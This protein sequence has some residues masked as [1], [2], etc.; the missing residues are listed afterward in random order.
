MADP[1]LNPTP[2][3]S[4]SIS[5]FGRPKVSNE[6]AAF[7]SV[8]PEVIPPSTTELKKTSVTEVS[9]A[10]AL[11]LADSDTLRTLAAAQVNGNR[12][13][14]DAV[15][16][17]LRTL[18]YGE[19]ALKYGKEV[20]DNSWKILDAE[21]QFR[22]TLAENRSDV[23]VTKDTG[24]GIAQ[25]AFNLAGSLAAL[26][27]GAINDRA[28]AATAGF[29]EQGSEW[30][31]DQKS[32]RFQNYAEANELMSALDGQD[33]LAEYNEAMAE[34]GASELLENIKFFGRSAGDAVGRVATDPALMGDFVAQNIGSL[35]PSVGL[36]KGAQAITAGTKLA[37]GAVPAAV[38]L[39]ESGAAYVGA[40]NRVM[41]MSPEELAAGSE[42][43]RRLIAEG[44]SHEEAAIE[45]STDAGMLAAL[46]QAPLAAAAGKFVERFEVSPT[47]VGSVKEGLAD[48][49][50]QI[51][52]EGF[53][54]GSGQF[55]QN[56]AIQSVADENQEI[57]EGVAEGA[58]L[59]A[60][61]GG[62]VAGL[63]QAPGIAGQGARAAVGAAAGAV[64]T[65]LSNID[66]QR[67]AASP[68]GTNATA[69]AVD[70]AEATMNSVVEQLDTDTSIDP[71]AE[72][73]VDLRSR[74]VKAL[75]VQQSDLDSM[76]E[77]VRNIV[78]PGG[79][80]LGEGESVPRALVTKAVMDTLQ[81][82][83]D[84]ETR[85]NAIL[86]L[87]E[88]ASIYESLKDLD[89]STLT[90]SL[91]EQINE[92]RSQLDTIQSNPT[93][94]RAVELAPTLTQKDLG[95]LP[96][97]TDANVGT[98]EVQQAVAR[99]SQLA[100]V[101]PTG[102]D[103]TYARVILNQVTSG[104]LGMEA[105][106]V[107]RLEAAAA[108]SELYA[109]NG[110]QKAT[111]S[112]G[113]KPEEDGL[114]IDRVR[115]MI[116]TDGR[117]NDLGQYGLKTHLG[118]ILSAARAG[119]KAQTQLLMEN[120]WNFNQSM[121][122]KL[123]AAN[124][125]ME[126]QPGQNNKVKYQAWNG[127]GWSEGEVYV[128]PKSE[129]SLATGKAIEAD[130]KTVADI[131]QILAQGL[132]MPANVPAVETAAMRY[133]D[134]DL[135]P[136]PEEQAPPRQR[137]LRKDAVLKTK[138]SLIDYDDVA[139]EPAPEPTPEPPPVRPTRPTKN[140]DQAPTPRPEPVQEIESEEYTDPNGN[141]FV[142][143]DMD[144]D[145]ISRLQTLM[146]DIL[147][148]S[149]ENGS[150]LMELVQGW[151]LFDVDGFGG[152]AEYDRRKILLQKGIVDQLLGGGPALKAKQ[153]LLHELGHLIDAELHLDMTGEEGQISHTNIWSLPASSVGR[154][155]KEILADPKHMFHAYLKRYAATKEG[156]D[157]NE[158]VFA[159]LMG[160]FLRN[161]QRFQEVAPNVYY[162]FEKRL[163][164][165][166]GVTVKPAETEPETQTGSIGNAANPEGQGASLV[167]GQVLEAAAEEAQ[168]AP[169]EEAREDRG[170]PAGDDST[171]DQTDP[172]EEGTSIEEDA[173]TEPTTDVGASGSGSVRGN[174]FT[175]LVKSAKGVV[176]F[177]RAY[178]I[179]ATKSLLVTS[180]S[181]IESVL[182]SVRNPGETLVDYDLDENQKEALT[183]LVQKEVRA[184]VDGM[185]AKLLTIPR[186]A[187]GTPTLKTVEGEALSPLDALAYGE[188]DFT[189]FMESRVLNLVDETTGEFDP[190]LI[191]LAAMAAMHW[192]MHA[193]PAKIPDA[194]E[195]A[196]MFGV[197]ESEVSSR[198]MEA[199]RNAM[200]GSL[201]V[202][203]LARE[204]MAFWGAK[205]NED[206]PMSDSLGIAQGLAS[207]LLSVMKGKITE[208]D[209]IDITREGKTVQ[210]VAIKTSHPNTDER[211]KQLSY[212][213]SYLKEAFIR[214]DEKP[215]YFDQPPAQVR[216]KQKRNLI[217]KLGS[218]MQKA[219]RRH[220]EQKFY[221]NT[222]F[223]N[224]LQGIGQD[225]W[226]DL[227]GFQKVI[228]DLMNREHRLSV[229]GR[230]T[231]LQKSWEG[232]MGHN[233]RLEA[234]AAKAG[235]NADD[236]VT[237]FDVYA[238]SNERIHQDGFNPQ[239]NKTMREAWA[240]TESI[241]DLTNP[242]DRHLFWLTVAQSSGLIKTE[243]VFEQEGEADPVYLHAKTAA[244]AEKKIEDTYGQAIELL[245][246][247]VR[248][249]EFD[250]K[251][252]AAAVKKA[253][254]G[255]E[256]LIHSL[257]AVAQYRV[258]MTS[259][260]EGAKTNFR[261]FLSLEADGKTD[262][263]M[264]ALVNHS[265]GLFTVD[266]I[267]NFRRGGFFLAQRGRTLNDQKRDGDID[268]YQVASNGTKV[269]LKAKI[270]TMKEKGGAK[271]AE[272][273]LRF[274]S[275]F[276][277]EFSYNEKTE[278]I[279]INRGLLKN[280]L[281]VSV[282]GSGAQGIA[283]KISGA[284]LEAFYER[285]TEL[286]MMRAETGNQNLQ[287]ADLPG[288]GGYTGA[289]DDLHT[290]S[291]SQVRYT[292]K[293]GGKYYIS[294]ETRD[295]K[296]APLKIL[297]PK[298]LVLDAK[299][300]EMLAHNL[301]MILVA[302]MREGIGQVMANPQEV[303]QVLQ[304]A[305]QIQS[306]TMIAHFRQAVK[307]TL[308]A[309]RASGELERGEFLSQDD[310]NEIYRK[311][312]RFGAVIEPAD[313]NENHLNLSGSESTKSSYEFTRSL[314]GRYGGSTR[315]PE[316]SDAGVAAAAM[317]TI[318]RGDAM[319]MVNYFASQDPDLRTLAVF[320]GL[321]MPADGIETISKQIN[322]AVAE[323]W[324]DDNGPRDLADSFADFTRQGERGPFADIKDPEALLE[325]ARTMGLEDVKADGLVAAM[326][327]VAAQVSEDLNQIATEIQAR[328]NVMKS[329][330]YSMDHMA[331][332]RAPHT[333]EGEVFDADPSDP[334][335]DD[336]LVGW[337]NL[338]YEEELSKLDADRQ[339]KKDRPSVEKPS[340]AF[341]KKVKE[342]G[343]EM[344]YRP[345]TRM[346]S[347]A[348]AKMMQSEGIAKD[349][350]DVLAVIQKALPDFTFLFG[351]SEEL[352]AYRDETY[353]EMIG[354]S[355][356][357]L[358]QADINNKVVYIAN[359]TSETVL[360]EAIHTATL[361]I[362]YQAYLDPSQL[363]EVQR[364]AIENLERLMNQFM[365]M[366]FS[367]A[368]RQ[369][370][371]QADG[372]VENVAHV[373]Q[374]QI[375]VAQSQGDALGKAIALNE[376]M[377]WA[378]SNQNLIDVM[379]KTKVRTPLRDLVFKA[380]GW[381]RKL[382]GLAPTQK[383]D[384]FS[385]ILLNTGAALM[386]DT[387][388]TQVGR[389]VELPVGS[390]ANQMIGQP[391][392]TRL[393]TVMER[394]E[395]KIAA[396]LR[397]RDPLVNPGEEVKIFDNANYAVNMFKFHGFDMDPQQTSAF[398]SIQV[399][400][401]STMQMDNR[402]LI[403][404]Q[405]I[406]NH[407]TKQLKPSDFEGY[408]DGNLRSQSRF[409]M[410]LG[411]YGYETD[412]QGRSNLMA[413]FLALSQVDP[414]FRKV[415]DGIDLPKDR[416]V[417]RESMDELLTSVTNSALDTLA[418]AT[419]GAGIGSRTTREALDRL[420]L[421]LSE[422]ETDD[423]LW[424]EKKAQDLFDT[425][426]EKG[427]KFLS[428]TGERIGQWADDQT[429]KS[430]GQQRNAVKD[431]I[432][433]GATFVAS[434]LN[435][436]RGTAMASA[437]TSLGNQTRK[438]PT[439]LVELMNEVIGMTNE[440]E[441][442][443]GMI[444][445]VKAS[446]SAMR[447]DYREEVPRLIAEKFSRE[448]E[449]EE[450]SA[451]HLVL[452]KTDTGTLR[453]HYSGADLR[454]LVT[455][456]AHL[457]AEIAQREAELKATA[458]PWATYQRKAKELAKF[459][460]TGEVVNN[461]LLR[462]ATAI[463]ALMGEP[464][465]GTDDAQTIELIDILTTL[466]ALREVDPS[467]IDRVA[468]LADT[469]AEGIDFLAGYLW[470]VAKDEKAK[471]SG[472]AA[473]YNHYK[474]YIPSDRAE[475]VS[476]LV[477]DD[478]E[479]NTLV[480]QGY[481]RI[482]EYK[483][484]GVETGKKSYYFS[485]VAGNGTYTQG[486]MQTIQQSA[487]GVDPR[488]GR[489]ISGTTAGV[490]TGKYLA[491]I[492]QRLR[493]AQRG[494]VEAL[495]P[496]YDGKGNVVAY[497]RH[498]A[499]HALA[500]LERSTHMGEMLG[501]WAGRQAEEELGQEFNRKLVDNLKVI[502]DRDKAKRS[503]EFVDISESQDAVHAD[504]WEMVPN[505]LRAYI[506]EVLG[507]DGFPI[508]KDMI[509]NAVGYRAASITDP[510]TGISR[511]SPEMQEGFR[512]VATVLFK[513]DAF[514][515]LATAEKAIQA[516]VSVVKST[517]VVRSI[518]IPMANLA[519]NFM[520]LSLHGVNVREMYQ[521][522]QTKLLEI[523][524]YQKNLK[525]AIDIKAE[526][527]A[528]R[529]NP[530]AVRRLETEL[531]SLEDANRRMSIWDLIEAGEFATISEGLT[532]ADAA[533]TTGKWADYIQGV[534]EKVP[535][536]FGTA[537][538]YAFI[539]RDTALFQGMARAMQY[540]DGL[541]KG[542]LYDHLRAQGKSKEEALR[543]VTEEFVNYNILPGRT[544]SY[545]DG[546]GLVW[547]PAFKLRS[548]KIARQHIINHP[549]RALMLTLGNPI[550]P[551]VPGLTIGSPIEDNMLTVIGDGRLG[552]SIGPGMAFNA[553]S[554][555]P[556]VNLTN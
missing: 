320:D 13:A 324:L 238:V 85:K 301:R 453:D 226:M 201:A 183:S 56:L 248:G 48:I 435:E 386:G 64:N 37:K 91:Q 63:M 170:E 158:E 82:G 131:Y 418:T 149:F 556:W 21:T 94:K 6:L 142:A 287:L 3:F 328:K 548:I 51:L 224:L 167:D 490:I 205:I 253:G 470:S 92:I 112:N 381:I 153:I 510:W 191:E 391:V 298:N 264:A 209:T 145:M 323:A 471:V 88:Q 116:L 236:V 458:K 531:K 396:H 411:K 340:A 271:H 196:K 195:V 498:M 277:G 100:D 476:L 160:F 139:V 44:M 93:F 156:N 230:N 481:T 241:L 26:G 530:D 105:Q 45:I 219:M 311:M 378:L 447:Q 24:I 72:P 120:L 512:K 441:G 146:A 200:S 39:G 475:G 163:D 511:L 216:S 33:R 173:G 356:V 204:I 2:N 474:G 303:N 28:G 479:H 376:F 488:T 539:T 525:R 66:A 43:Y 497:E 508:R 172:E 152:F 110:A 417:S 535:A 84:P 472:E 157:Q 104:K 443:L 259:N 19:I 210:A 174:P 400:L 361:Q 529:T 342:H 9:K 349:A 329:M 221:R 467:S 522:Y 306:Q 459:M 477:R 334:N 547:F 394:F 151:R 240:S 83:T 181:P 215:Y 166:F 295:G 109:A 338:R 446:V 504:S 305:T 8:R 245:I 424:I 398:R 445:R 442:V 528:Q 332:G 436:N 456:K 507:D 135:T 300:R 450:W 430:L 169:Q 496:I 266:E 355:P 234:H 513:D 20:A 185:N 409:D 397:D 412:L 402:A 184:L 403:Q 228:P 550:V 59:G 487:S 393:Q 422:I 272:A 27:V 117:K 358:G 211:I 366:D 108:L 17:D 518:I 362:V 291:T 462:N 483:G 86:W 16:Q 14:D 199:S 214:G 252:F 289:L 452:G 81:N 189:G 197:R 159:E 448:L 516:G 198:M 247:F 399:A 114:S 178:T 57:S 302:P 538:R 413:S 321:E 299:N 545:V 61:G 308:A 129:N 206:A 359:A 503:D 99:V 514:R 5:E 419:S 281:T 380:T 389:E 222:P 65:R 344:G 96:E 42:D 449:A 46:Q 350:R 162:F 293:D 98:P 330:E 218:K 30:F 454:K 464:G 404:T 484:A 77:S 395:T 489:T 137:R 457:A 451:L 232:V 278:E 202:E 265:R 526:I 461:N 304:Q 333:N 38:A 70:T 179:D 76:P 67:D 249:S 175:N 466:Y 555:H 134:Q 263:P 506:K 55:N 133:A 187:K 150:R 385:N 35:V 140:P 377:A 126:I 499:P 87:N 491:I 102:I 540:G 353:P 275:A 469:E 354:T 69:Q 331:S 155:I 373:L 34:P 505:D 111:L 375:A 318:S 288:L 431:T 97:I 369:D 177:V 310:Y 429:V 10:K 351:S 53:Q 122:N 4:S 125:S 89:T 297:R 326:E 220:Q 537:G 292:K 279:T 552:Y 339:A 225:A 434:L 50:K 317:M 439:A 123:A 79:E 154:E 103:P 71:V 40:T 223:V 416:Q 367:R 127:S 148:S 384:M 437:M 455:D 213:R 343:V 427:S 519:S 536:K 460:V 143:E 250:G 544:R 258:A 542:V 352:T 75:A 408:P 327:Q 147:E 370:L 420:S 290:L 194:E 270:E 274:L 360:H 493:N 36:A 515:Y 229:E 322:K 60:L 144:A 251:A 509:N 341:D 533:L 119:N 440:N 217:G 73:V 357:E 203:S 283:D 49:G 368:L 284:L 180:G 421:V 336:K 261:H 22:T 432:R 433:Q 132:G 244:D 29:V 7:G 113:L 524:K 414:E 233:M 15:L 80:T 494:P 388:I 255:N 551:N 101:N 423:R 54:E 192:V 501:A 319:M 168:A 387:R 47:S 345:I 312:S 124:A 260:E 164:R 347:R 41:A 314:E 262:G 193:N 176:R 337:L 382:L 523:T 95:K 478:S 212:A 58:A 553:P 296:K 74:L 121:Q 426:D 31:N 428:T 309:K 390:V 235:K 242:K 486:A 161:P 286:E 188:K 107:K 237:H 541:S 521:G 186:N 18:P 243:Q 438:V 208:E 480:A 285:L 363:D 138:N 136:E 325:I 401:A 335:F 415:L 463:A 12:L 407:V 348:M 190:T 532:E 276:S 231:Q 546:M 128:N 182:D 11:A 257:L 543:G 269:F 534:I 32:D 313:S 78:A 239:A 23:E 62:S 554:L 465:K 130:A 549:F 371:E 405:R 365:D 254:G 425:A 68:V 227:M 246:P 468:K 280:P 444:N 90:E 485:T 315:L 392:D 492:Q 527:T 316:P 267:R 517:I 406:F 171:G 364:A 282:Y 500:A 374:R 482:G 256:K 106:A 141:A 52:E 410:L 1:R 273:M 502:W 346:T 165:A 25:G 383:L 268:L 207:E 520:Q 495:L 473:L 115:Q 118:K 379:K 294:D 307:E 372:S